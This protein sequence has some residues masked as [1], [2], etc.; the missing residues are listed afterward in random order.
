MIQ[1]EQLSLL[2]GSKQLL[3]N[4]QFTIFPG[5]RVG[6]VGANGT[7]KSSL[8]AL[9]R[10]ELKEDQGSL[11]I[12][13]SWRIASVAQE[14]PALDTAARD[15]V[16]T[17]DS[18]YVAVHAALKEAEA[19]NNGEAIAR[20]H[21]QLDAIG[22]YQIEARASGLLAGLGFTPEQFMAPVRSFSGG[23]RMRLN[24]SQALIARA[25]LLLLDEPTNHLDL[26][27][28]IWL[29][30]WLL[31]FEG[32]VIVI[33]HDRDF[34]DG[35][36]SHTIHIEQGTT[37]CYQGNY[38]S[39]Q[40]QRTERRAQAQQKFAKE[41]ERRAHL[42]SFVDRFRAKASKAKQ[43]QSRL[44]ALE[45]L[46]A[47]EP[48]DENHRYDLSFPPPEKL[49]NPLIQLEQVQAGYGSAVILEA[50]QFNLVPGSR[51]GLL[52]RNGAGKSTLTKL[53]AGE[54]P[55]LQGS[56]EASAGLAIG[57]FAQHQLDTLR[58]Q[59]T[60]MEHL[61]RL[62][63]KATEQ[64][65]RDF[66]GRFGFQGDRAFEPVGPFSGGEKARL[67]LAL[68]VYQRPN[69]L[70]LDEPTNHLDLDMREALVAA[71]QE[72]SGAMVVVS[73]DRHFLRATVDDYYLVA[74]QNVEPFKGDLD[75]YSAWLTAQT[76][77][78]TA[79]TKATTEPKDAKKAQRQAA[80]A[81]RLQLKP[82]NDRLKKVEA[83]MQKL[84]QELATLNA[85]L[86][87]PDLYQQESP[88]ALSALFQ[89]QGQLEKELEAVE[90]EWLELETEL[91]LLR[92]T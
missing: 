34:L 91:E 71:L 63:P 57:Y 80:A 8:F 72:F 38:S 42:Q 59:D 11:H 86:A 66:L 16:I 33:S 2:R 1:A 40:R 29:E 54:L 87:D 82:L 21:G 62:D 68:L 47:T 84:T 6:L 43:A 10:G 27:T 45:K 12:P 79:A 83:A 69:L 24:L 88:T 61:Q 46:T 26:D 41:Q 50:I 15:Y 23:W 3:N 55:P 49:P 85:R 81:Q 13:K 14:T 74:N 25:D 65:L 77:E 53:L 78:T 19:N 76:Q 37:H 32:T 70:L 73:H 52:G 7:G 9:I 44:K 17:G 75:D 36:I 4:A 20:L 51:I 89:Q 31:R 64:S 30:Q 5:Q 28:I 90:A 22:G 60:A 35:V 56:R 48:L 92:D 67:V 58:I 18:E 39:F